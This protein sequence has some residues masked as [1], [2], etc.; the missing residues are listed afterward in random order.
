VESNAN[1]V[2]IAFS[3]EDGAE[4]VQQVTG[5]L[6]RALTDAGLEAGIVIGG[7]ALS[8]VTSINL[9]GVYH[10]RSMTELAAFAQG[11]RSSRAAWRAPAGN[12]TA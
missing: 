7:P 3:T 8:A 1:L 6:R 10:A 11:L 4:R 9:P 5:D 12:T 2:W